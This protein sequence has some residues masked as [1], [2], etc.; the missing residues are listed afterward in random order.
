MKVKKLR[1]KGIVPMFTKIITTADVYSEAESLT[2]S[3]IID[4]SKQGVIKDIQT[5]ISVGTSVRFVKVGDKVSLNFTKYAKQRYKKDN[6]IEQDMEEHYKPATV[7]EI[8]MLDINNTSR[9]FIDE[10]DVEF[11]IHDFDEEEIE[12]NTSGL[13]DIKSPIILS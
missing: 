8:P 3:G 7:F 11:I 6:S 12:I 1:I 5:V 13:I 10:N 4:A 2:N 9:L